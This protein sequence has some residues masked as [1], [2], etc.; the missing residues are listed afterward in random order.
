MCLSDIATG[1]RKYIYPTFWLG[2]TNSMT[3]QYHWPPQQR[4]HQNNREN[5]KTDLQ[6]SYNPSKYTELPTH[7]RLEPWIT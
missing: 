2:N 6:Y 3:D 5:R 1:D 4:T 7:R